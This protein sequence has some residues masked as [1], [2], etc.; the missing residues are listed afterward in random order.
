MLR[1]RIQL[2]GKA[3]TNMTQESRS[4]ASPDL[5][6]EKSAASDPT[7]EK[8]AASDTTQENRVERL[9]I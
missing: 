7:Q 1:I 8:R 2:E 6:Q 9:R 4:R 3:A 5:T